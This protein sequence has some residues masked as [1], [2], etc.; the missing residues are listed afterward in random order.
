M[1]IFLFIL[2]F[3]ILNFDYTNGYPFKYRA[4][5]NNMDHYRYH[6]M[7]F[8]QR[9]SNFPLKK[10]DVEQSQDLIG[11]FPVYNPNK[12][13]PPS[14]PKDSKNIIQAVNRDK[15]VLQK[16]HDS[17]PLYNPDKK[18]SLHN[19]MNTNH[20]TKL[21]YENDEMDESQE[22]ENDLPMYTP[23][24][25]IPFYKTIGSTIRTNLFSN[26]QNYP[27]YVNELISSGKQKLFNFRK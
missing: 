2:L 4:C 13:S 11:T 1:F 15:E 14:K 9:M 17:L 3:K 5:E 18:I 6:T 26:N 8:F 19:P 12:R 10:T 21:F 20:E 25:K 16:T 27:K 24:K 7:P 23:N 22:M